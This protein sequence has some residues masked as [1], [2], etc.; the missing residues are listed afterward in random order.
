M[1]RIGILALTM[2]IGAKI[3]GAEAP[4]YRLTVGPVEEDLA[5]VT[6]EAAIPDA[7]VGRVP[8][9]A[10]ADG[11]RIPADLAPGASGGVLAWVVP[12]MK[13]GETASWTLKFAD[14]KDAPAPRVSLEKAASGTIDVAMEGKTF[15]RFV[16]GE[17]KPYLWPILLDGV[18]MTR[19]YPMEDVPGEDKDHVHQKSFWFTH[20]DVNGADFWAE[21]GK[22]GKIV[23]R[24]AVPSQARGQVSGRIA[25]A[26]DWVD[27]DGKKVI[28]QTAAYAFWDLGAAGRFIDFTTVLTA[29]EGPVT[30]GDTKEG[31]FGIRLA[32]SMKEDRG[33]TIVNSRGATGMK[34]CWG[35]PAEWIDYTGKVE[36]KTFGVTI[37]D[38]PKSFRHPTTWH[39][40]NYGLFA[41]NPFGLKEFTGKKQDGTLK[42]EKGGTVTFSYRVFFHP[43]TT[44]EAKVA[45]AYRAFGKPPQVKV[46]QSR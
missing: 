34:G 44:E 11:A 22:S 18:H 7:P 6:L 12:E 37:F 43:G 28:S 5:L 21:S 45:A 9:L 23:V 32:E 29:S 16:P 39:V 2:L 42:V 17:R 26:F 46:E 31:T 10:A 19:H 35:K 38:G 15:T 25:G 20:G 30:F 14:A 40:R 27:R 4:E 36:G 13:K 3:V 41:A 1:K 8:V 33:G 24:E